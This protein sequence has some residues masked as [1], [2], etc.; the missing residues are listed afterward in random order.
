MTILNLK[1]KRLSN[2]IRVN[3]DTVEKVKYF[4]Y[5]PIGSLKSSDGDCSK[6][7]NERIAMAKPRMGELTTLWK[8]RSTPVALNIRLVE[9]LV[10]TVLSYG[11]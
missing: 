2:T 3:N 1:L 10:W 6:Y 8:D 4:K 9:T 5:R 7:L 11:A